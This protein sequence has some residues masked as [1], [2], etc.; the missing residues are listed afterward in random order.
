MDQEP[1]NKRWITIITVLVVVATLFG[2]S[3]LSKKKPSKP[4]KPPENAQP[5]IATTITLMP[6][7]MPI[8]IETVGR[9]QAVDD[10]QV[11]SEVSGKVEPGTYPFRAGV[12]FKKYQVMLS[13]D[14][15]QEQFTLYSQRSQFINQ[16]THLI[17]EMTVDFPDRVSIWEDFL[18]HLNVQSPLPRLPKV[19]NKK[20]EKFLSAMQI[21]SQYYDI[22][23][24]EARLEKYMIRAPFDGVVVQAS[25]NP[26]D[27][28]SQSKVLG[29]FQS[30][31]LFEVVASVALKELLFVTVGQKV[32]LFSP[33][34]NQSWT[35]KIVRLVPKVEEG[36]QMAS[37]IT[38]VESNTLFDGMIVELKTTTKLV[39]KVFAL[40]RGYVE[41]GRTVYIQEDSQ[42][43]A[44][45]VHIL[46]QGTKVIIRAFTDSET[47]FVKPGSFEKQ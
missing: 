41:G 12:T 27:I 18:D 36:A 21:Y 37:F 5:L 23:S 10:I 1:T 47:I 43:K 34:M 14:A 38:R 40:P 45:Q 25:V 3:V 32:T 28:V 8:E 2:F 7:K 16:V 17:S 4:I 42:V 24:L 13:I 6:E 39:P 31:Q 9:L 44:K 33:E 26:G 22:R 19:D 15:D 35:G 11:I 30:S 20:E 29:R 46:K